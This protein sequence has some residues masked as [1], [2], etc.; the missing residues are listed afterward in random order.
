MVKLFKDNPTGMGAG[1]LPVA[2]HQ[3]RLYFLFGQEQDT[4][5]WSDFGG[6]S[7]GSETPLQTALREGCEELNGF[8]GNK[9][10]VRRYLRNHLITKLKFDQYTAFVMLVPFDPDLPFYFQNNHTFTKAHLPRQVG[11]DGLFEKNKIQWFTLADVLRQ[12]K[13]FRPFYRNIV[14]LLP[15]YAKEIKQV[16][17]PLLR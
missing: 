2:I 16:A 4:H 9:E 13:K 3:G 5:Q 17:L 15:V 12:R 6:G 1:I 8:Y 7:Q 11:Q 14:D 10:Q